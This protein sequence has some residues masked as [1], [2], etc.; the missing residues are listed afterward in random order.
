MGDDC[1]AL[2]YVVSVDEELMGLRE[3]AVQL[4]QEGQRKHQDDEAVGERLTVVY[5]RLQVLGRNVAEV[6]ASKILAGL[7]F[8]TAVQGRCTKSFSGGW[9]MQISLAR[10]LAGGVSHAVEEDFDCCVP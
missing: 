1:S 10:A 3:E 5:E 8:S 9:R 4:Q 2:E 7:G 6:R